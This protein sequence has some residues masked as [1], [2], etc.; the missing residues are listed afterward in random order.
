MQLGISEKLQGT[1]CGDSKS[2][3]KCLKDLTIDSKVQN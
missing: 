1:F 2:F 3:E